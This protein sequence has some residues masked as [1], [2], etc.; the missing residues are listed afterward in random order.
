MLGYIPKGYIH[1]NPWSCSRNRIAPRRRTAV[2]N[3]F[4]PKDPFAILS[5]DRLG[6]LT[7]TTTGNV[8]LL[9]IVDRFSK[10]VRAVPLAGVTATD[11]SSAFCRVWISL[12]GPLDSVLTA[13]GPQFASLIFQCACNLMSIQNV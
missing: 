12:Y 8:F 10:L 3:V 4:P 11:V 5:M 13:N 9:I 1:D 6:P 7:E 2:L